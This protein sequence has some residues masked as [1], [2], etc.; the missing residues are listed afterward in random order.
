MKIVLILPVYNEEEIL[1]DNVETL[2]YFLKKHFLENEWLIVLAD[3]AS[4]D[5]TTDIG[6]KLARDYSHDV[7]YFRLEQK[8]KGLALRH[9]CANF[10]ADVYFFIDADLSVG[11]KA[12]RNVF[13]LMRSGCDIV[14]GSRINSKYA[15]KRSAL[16]KMISIMY[17]IL[18]TAVFAIDVSDPP[19]GFKAINSKTVKN[20]LPLVYDNQWFFDTELLIVAT[21]HKYIIKEINV[22]WIDGRNPKRPHKLKIIPTSVIYLK[23]ILKRL[24]SNN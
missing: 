13:D 20:L 8:G 4:T 14:V 24:L 15:V 6:Q 7:Q 22:E 18:I 9:A 5:N 11:L 10:N 21:Q 16:R 19:C 17:N 3:N 2:Y 23:A 12:I 1:K